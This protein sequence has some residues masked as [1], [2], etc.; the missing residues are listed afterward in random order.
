[1]MKINRPSN[2]SL[3][4][5]IIFLAM[6]F[7]KS[8]DG[9]FRLGERNKGESIQV[10][11][12][13]HHEDCKSSEL[14]AYGI[15]VIG[16]N[17][18]CAW[19]EI[20][21]SENRTFSCECLPGY[22]HDGIWKT[23]KRKCYN[24]GICEDYEEC[25]YGMCQTVIHQMS[26]CGWNSWHIAKNH[27]PL[28]V[29]PPKFGGDPYAG[30]RKRCNTSYD[31]EDYDICHKNLCKSACH[32]HIKPCAYSEKCEVENHIAHC[33]D[34]KNENEHCQ[35]DSDCDIKSF[36][37]NITSVCTPLCSSYS[38]NDNERCTETIDNST[39]T[40]MR[41]Y[42]CDCDSKSLDGD[43]SSRCYKGK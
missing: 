24:S 39:T 31:C 30:C 1:M 14:C 5:L 34:G 8:A 41:S 16:C 26:K 28:C 3:A 11:T 25:R 15:C 12:C 10:E 23:C 21:K 19:N 9:S 22:V 42:K 32:P 43:D 17:K 4:I 27:K 40:V 37:N 35:E 36:C 7:L 38:C 13:A 2:I 33:V 6:V 20:C 18:R 29:C